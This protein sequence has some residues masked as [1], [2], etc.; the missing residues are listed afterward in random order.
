M[1]ESLE[2]VST[3]EVRPSSGETTGEQALPV[4]ASPTGSARLGL[5]RSTL[6]MSGITMFSRLLGLV[7]EQVRAHLLGTTFASDA[8]GIAFQIP[9]LLRRLVGEGAM[10]AAFIPIFTEE[11][12]RHGEEA[13]FRFARR[14]FNLSLHAMDELHRGDAYMGFMA[15]TLAT[16]M[17]SSPSESMEYWLASRL[18]FPSEPR[19]SVDENPSPDPSTVSTRTRSSIG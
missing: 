18:T 19:D 1:T 16:C 4:A 12:E 3:N 7:R 15:S 14:F 11:K 2:P 6:G 5:L 10:S 13:A 9:N 8:F 17:Y